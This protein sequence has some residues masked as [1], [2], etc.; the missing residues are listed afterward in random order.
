MSDAFEPSRAALRALLSVPDPSA[1]AH[2]DG[3]PRSKVFRVLLNPRTRALA[4]SA[5][6]LAALVFPRASRLGMVGRLL[7]QFV[8]IGRGLTRRWH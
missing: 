3:F 2:V 4:L 7:P 6:A 1:P 8:R 5:T